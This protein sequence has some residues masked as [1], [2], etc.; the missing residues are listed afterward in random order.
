MSKLPLGL[1]LM[2]VAGAAHAQ[3][4]T[5]GQAITNSDPLLDR[6]HG[7]GIKLAPGL[8]LTQRIEAESIYSNN[9]FAEEQTKE[10]AFAYFLRPSLQFTGNKGDLNYSITPSFEAARYQYR[11][12]EGADSYV[13]A[14]LDSRLSWQAA[15]AHNFS[16]HLRLNSGHDPFGTIRTEGQ[17]GHSGSLDRWHDLLAN[18]KYHFGTAEAKI[19]LETQ[20]ETDARKYVSNRDV[21]QFLD[22]RINRANETVLYYMSSRTSLVADAEYSTIRFDRT[23]SGFPSHDADATNFMGGIRWKATGKTLGDL[24]IG[25]YR[26]NFSDPSLASFSVVNWVATVTWLPVSYS[27]FVLQTGRLAQESYLS[28][29]S[30]LD[31]RYES[32]EWIHDWSSRFKTR[33]SFAH[34]DGN[35]VGSNRKDK[36]NAGVLEAAYQTTQRWSVTAGTAFSNRDSNRPLTSYEESTIHL[37]LR[38]AR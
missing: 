30:F 9:V 18:A 33:L 34:V 2:F 6:S 27:V 4:Q 25:R 10:S 3:I 24:R 14:K 28:D 26:R 31:S 21:T 20:V 32:L 7:A 38:Y 37:G 1:V 35:F 23:A 29:V 8:R 22:Y 12:S 15:T 17:A 5:L 19:N 16:G 13:D 36:L 11:A